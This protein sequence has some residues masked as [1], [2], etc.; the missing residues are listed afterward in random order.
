MVLKVANRLVPY[1][2]FPHRALK[3][4][5]RGWLIEAESLRAGG[6]NSRF[7]EIPDQLWRQP[8]NVFTAAGS[9]CSALGTPGLR[10]DEVLPE[11]PLDTAGRLGSAHRQVEF[12]V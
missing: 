2:E 12:N 1:V 8:V 7:E 5:A 3:P 9:N 10:S 6:C 11:F 4:W